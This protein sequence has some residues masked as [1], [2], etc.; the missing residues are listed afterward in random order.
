MGW[1]L[2]ALGSGVLLCP[3]G[4]AI[5]FLRGLRLPLSIVELTRERSSS[6]DQGSFLLLPLPSIQTPYLPTLQRLSTEIPAG[7]S[8]PCD[9]KR[10][11]C[12]LYLMCLAVSQAHSNER[13]TKSLSLIIVPHNGKPHWKSRYEYRALRVGAS[14]PM[15]RPPPAPGT[16]IVSGL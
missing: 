6:L 5:R 13:Q 3:S 16:F 8:P 4:G 2:W 7:C 10:S 15:P 14:A 1:V 9:A 11:T 12:T